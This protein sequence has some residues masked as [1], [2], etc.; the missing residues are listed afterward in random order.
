ML[1][2]LLAAAFSAFAAS[3]A[4][5]GDACFGSD[6]E[7]MSAALKNAG[8]CR[9]ALAKF[10]ACAWGSSADL[11]FGDVVVKV[12]EGEFLA[13]LT[14]AGKANY[15]A[16]A[17]LCDYE[18]A[19]QEGTMYRS[20]EALCRAEVASKFA[21][22]PA[23]ADRALPRASFDCAKA[24]TPLEKAICV[25]PA[26]GRADLVLSR[27]YKEGMASLTPAERDALNADERK[28]M[29]K[30]VADCKLATAP[31]KRALACARAAFEARFTA[32]E[33]CSDN[34]DGA[35]TKCLAAPQ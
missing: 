32:I 12:C 29:A 14:P 9:A 28:W 25:D 13:K 34:P 18:H 22:T 31:D 11:A 7:A 8:S 33:E 4:L 19:R 16:E 27:V 30:V 26:L 20:A 3:A 6:G 5:A 1:R 24:Q 2:L 21:A 35:M 17:G 23:L 15:E 10:S